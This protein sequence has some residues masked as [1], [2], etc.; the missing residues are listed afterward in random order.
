VRLYL[1]YF[2]IQKGKGLLLRNFVLPL[3]P[4]MDCEFELVLPGEAKIS[5]KYRE[6]IGWSSLLYG[7]FE[8]AELE[9]VRSYLR[10][11]SNVFDIG[12]NVG[13]FSVLMSVALRQSGNVWAFEPE[14]TNVKRLKLNIELNGVENV[15]IF[16]CALGEKDAHKMLQM[17]HDPA[18]PSLVKV[19]PG[20]SDGTDILVQM[21]TLDAVWDDGGKPHISF[22][23][24]DV[25]G[26]ELQVLKGASI[27]L[28]E[29]RPTMLIEANTPEQLESLTKLLEGY[30]YEVIHPHGFV[31][32]N[33]LFYHSS[34]AQNVLRLI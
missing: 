7:T 18:Y 19:E 24:M 9:F 8:L 26:S 32:H 3:L 30:G 5:L 13:I 27:F 14:P 6:T 4:S 15:R 16:S 28:K 11:G 20:F 33:Y 23:K 29:C 10:P 12:A 22:I 2:P 31:R 25:E 1:N 21:R 17:S 34:C